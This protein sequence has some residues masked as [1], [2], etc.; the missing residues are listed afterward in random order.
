MKKFITRNDIYRRYQKIYKVGYCKLQTTLKGRTAKY[1]NAGDYGWNYDL[2]EVDPW[3][4]ILTGYRIPVQGQE[5]NHRDC[6]KLEHIAETEQITD[7]KLKYLLEM[8]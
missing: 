3:T 5:L 2:Y 8:I 6:E 4:C 1:Y 7:E